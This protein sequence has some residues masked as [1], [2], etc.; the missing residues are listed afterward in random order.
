MFALF[1]SVEMA[2]ILG[3]SLYIGLLDF[4]KAFDFLNRKTLLKD[5][6]HKGIGNSLLKNLYQTTQ[7]FI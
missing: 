5:L 6:M 4:E 7:R 1:L 3:K 2:S